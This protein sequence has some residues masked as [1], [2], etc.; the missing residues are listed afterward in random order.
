M[1]STRHGDFV[2]DI[3]KRGYPASKET[4]LLKVQYAD[5]EMQRS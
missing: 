2:A 5:A 1:L 3:A 4:Q